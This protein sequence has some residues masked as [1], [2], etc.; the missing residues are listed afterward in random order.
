MA[1]TRLQELRQDAGYKSARSFAE[2]LSCN[3]NTYMSYEQGTR[4]IPTDIAIEI[5]DLLNITMDELYGRN[6][7]IHDELSRLYDSMDAGARV[8]LMVVAR[9]LALSHS[10][11]SFS[12]ETVN[13]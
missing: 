5:C 2:H 8:T 1:K 4:V 3:P 7:A 12:Y 13:I 10:N 11:Q 9:S 6:S